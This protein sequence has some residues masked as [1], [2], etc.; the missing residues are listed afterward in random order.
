MQRLRL[1]HP[2]TGSPET[3]VRERG[4]LYASNS[5]EK[6]W[7]ELFA[8]I[9]ISRKLNGGQPLKKPQGKGIIITKQK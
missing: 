2:D 7:K 4:V 8:L 9:E 3:I 6:K 1:Y 5:S